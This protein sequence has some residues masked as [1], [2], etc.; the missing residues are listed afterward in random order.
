MNLKD[1]YA[2]PGAVTGA[3]E[4][5]NAIRATAAYVNATLPWTAGVSSE[6]TG[7]DLTNEAIQVAVYQAAVDMANVKDIDK[8]EEEEDYDY[9]DLPPMTGRH[10]Q[11]PGSD[12]ESEDKEGEGLLNLPS[13]SFCGCQYPERQRVKKEKTSLIFPTNSILQEE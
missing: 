11:D 3:E 5:D 4:I 13:S 2:E 1:E 12:S 6:I 8:E 9:A 10:D 7:V